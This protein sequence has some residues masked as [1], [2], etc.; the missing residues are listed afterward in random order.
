MFRLCNQRNN[1]LQPA[2]G[3]TAL[4]W[5]VGGWT[6]RNQVVAAMESGQFPPA[7]GESQL[8]GRPMW[9]TRDL[10][11]YIRDHCA[12]R[13]MLDAIEFFYSKQEEPCLAA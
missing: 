12:T 6:L 1:R 7:S 13:Y 4:A 10:L 3:L 2:S 8:D 11:H 5:K 9:T